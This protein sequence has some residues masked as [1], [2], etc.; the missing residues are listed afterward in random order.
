MPNY[1]EKI[2]FHNAL[3]EYKETKSAKAYEIVGKNFIKICE[4]YLNKSNLINYSKDRKDDMVSEGVYD[5]VRYIDNY[6]VDKMEKVLQ[7]G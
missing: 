6:D 2:E 5:M 4:N 7:S 3:K 1:I